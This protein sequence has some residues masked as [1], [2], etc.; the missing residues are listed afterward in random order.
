MPALDLLLDEEADHLALVGGLHLLGD[1]HLDPVRA[2]GCLERPR[3]LVVVRDRD[4]PEPGGLGRLEQHVHRRGAV[5]RVVGVHVEVDVDV[6]ARRKPLADRRLAV[7]RV[8]AR[9][10]A[11]VD[12]LEPFGRGAPLELVVGLL[13]RSCRR[14]RSSLSTISRCELGAQGLGVAWLEQQAALAVVERLLVLGQARDDGHG[15][16]RD[17]PKDV[18]RRR[19]PSRSTP[20]P[21][22]ASAAR[23]WASEP[24]VGPANVTRSRS[25]RGS[26]TEPRS[27]GSRDQIVACQ[28]RCAGSRRS[29][30]RNTRSELRSSSAA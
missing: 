26:V 9:S 19:A 17:R 11:P 12:L 3:D 2:L 29:A 24:S 10:H 21:R 4:R 1:D 14:S 25:A 16:A 18:L 15:A 7:R 30:R 28:G 20:R 8:A 5:V 13:P 6:V 23:C 27:L 22:S